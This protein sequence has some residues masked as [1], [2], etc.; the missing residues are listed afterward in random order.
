MVTKI[1]RSRRRLTSI[2]L[3][4][5]LPW[6]AVWLGMYRLHSLILTFALYHGVCLLPAVVWKRR[7]WRDSLRPPSGHE[8]IH[9]CVATALVL[10]IAAWVYLEIGHVFVDKPALMA[11]LTLRGFAARDL[12]P[13]G[14]YFVVVNAV[15]EELF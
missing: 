4:T 9:L 5:L 6:P 10:P 2:I 12:L 7:L 15:V 8:I 14:L 1:T 3:L 11:A 13:L